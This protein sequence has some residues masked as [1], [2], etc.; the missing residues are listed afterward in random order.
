MLAH[1]KA[2]MAIRRIR[3]SEVAAVA[4]MSTATFSF[5]VHGV[6]ELAPH[7]RR[8][9]TEFLQA[10]E[11]WLFVDIRVIPK[12]KPVPEPTSVEAGERGGAR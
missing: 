6:Q 9:V 5:V 10:D 1:L 12:L 11:D 2:A 4:K 3:Q 8:R 7:L